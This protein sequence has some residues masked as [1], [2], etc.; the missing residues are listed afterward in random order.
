MGISV[1]KKILISMILLACFSL[2]AQERSDTIHVAHY[3]IHLAFVDFAG[4]TLQG[5]ATLDVVSKMSQLEN[6]VL[7]LIKFTVDS[8]KIEGVITTF[9]HDSRQLTITLPQPSKANDTMKVAIYYHG[10]P[11]QNPENQ[12]WGGGICFSGEYAFNTGISMTR[13]PHSYG[14]AWYPCIDLFTDKS[15]Y[16][17]HIRTTSDKMAICGGIL[18]DTTHLENGDIIWHWNLA[19]PVPAYLSSVA[20]GFYSVY[21]DTVQGMEKAIPVEIYT[22][23]SLMKRVPGSFANLKRVI[24]YYEELFGPYQFD[25]IGYVGIDFASGAMEH[26][27]NIGYPNS[28]ING[29]LN[30]QS[31]MVHELAHSWFGNLYTCD[32]AEEMWLNEGFARY[33]EILVDEYLYPD[34]NPE[35]DPA[36]KGFRDLHRSVLRKAHINDGDYF[37]LNN[38]PQHTTYGSTA[39]NKGGIIVHTL[40]HYMGDT[41]FFAGLKALFNE[42]A[43]KNINSVQFFNFLSQTTGLNVMDFFEAF[44]NQP[45]FLHYSIDSIRL[46]QSPNHYKVYVKQKLHQAT[47]FCNSNRLEITFF[48]NNGALH[49]QQITF[50]GASGVADVSIPFHPVFGVVDFYEKI[51]DAI[52]DYNLTINKTG[53]YNCTQ[54]DFTMAVT[55]IS[56][57]VFVRIEHNLVSPDPLKNKH[58][59]IYRISDNHYWRIEYLPQENF[60]GFFQFKYS[61][62]NANHLDY[63]LLQDYT[64]Q[65]LILLYR[66]DAS[67]DWRVIP[68]QRLTDADV[69]YVRITQLLP[70]EYTFATA[71]Y[72]KTKKNYP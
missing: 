53:N 50:S 52:I 34:D 25:K 41:L 54:A 17:C 2:Q 23:P 48:G 64:V 20:V 68:F 26:A 49:T 47:L 37:A 29:N 7:D 65:D 40:R 66:R 1:K 3:D 44:V 60:T 24:G 11:E 5:N 45:G 28:A 21:R 51:A 27:T 32:K 35:T 67:E 13:I 70:G 15:T 9:Q 36:K 57:E 56:D 31:L 71:A 8:V 46:F 30:Y 59:D 61:A 18:T 58:P 69:G 38:I 39:Y 14:R 33:C 19:Q 72:V 22:A 63:G 42:Y 12:P 43:F 4:K 16:N 55:E 62:L 10:I 6:I